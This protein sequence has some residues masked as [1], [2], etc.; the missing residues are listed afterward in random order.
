MKKKNNFYVCHSIQSTMTLVFG[1]L[2]SLLNFFLLGCTQSPLISSSNTAHELAY[3]KQIA[4]AT[5]KIDKYDGFYQLFQADMTQ[6][7]SSIQVAL[8]QRKADFLQWDQAKLQKERDRA[9]QEMATEA[10]FF[11]RFYTP[12]SDYDDFHRANSI[13]K[14]YLE[15]NH[16]RVEGKAKKMTQ[17]FSDIHQLFPHFN[18]FS[19]GYEVVFPISTSALEVGEKKVVI[20][21]S[22]GNASFTF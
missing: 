13:W 22:L 15:F 14:I 5:K 8:L 3:E 2:F 9:F 16:Q 6:I 1:F 4:S 11:L 17:K 7:S 18:R 20:T 19:T 21:S 10:K 12:E